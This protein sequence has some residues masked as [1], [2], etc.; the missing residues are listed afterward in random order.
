[1]LSKSI[2]YIFRR[3]SYTIILNKYNLEFSPIESM[4]M[5]DTTKNI[6]KI[7]IRKILT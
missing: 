3:N 1:M 4:K 7:Y 2:I 6:I 5:A